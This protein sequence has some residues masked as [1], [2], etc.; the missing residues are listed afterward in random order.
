MKGRWAPR[1]RSFGVLWSS[2]LLLY[3]DEIE[4]LPPHSASSS[5]WASIATTWLQ[6]SA[7]LIHCR[8]VYSKPSFM[9]LFLTILFNLSLSTGQ[10]PCGSQVCIH[11]AM[12]YRPISNLSVLSKLLERLVAR[13][14]GAGS[15][16]AGMAVAIPI[17]NVDGRRHT[18]NFSKNIKNVKNINF[19]V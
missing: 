13:Q 7:H 19:K 14:L 8:P 9:A 6:L 15:Y 1:L 18:N 2:R 16:L 11:H 12:C 17:L 3:L 4:E 10:V 5:L